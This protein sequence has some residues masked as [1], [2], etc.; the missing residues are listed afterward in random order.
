MPVLEH[1]HSWNFGKGLHGVCKC[2]A[3]RDFPVVPWY[4]PKIERKNRELFI[5]P[6]VYKVKE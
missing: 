4:N 2:G 1:S 5:L 3:E 6:K